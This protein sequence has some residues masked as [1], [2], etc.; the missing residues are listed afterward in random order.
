[1][2]VL[3]ILEKVDEI[4]RIIEELKRESKDLDL[5][6]VCDILEEYQIMLLD[7]TVG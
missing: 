7:K 6:L 3:E 2:T 4:D 5:N 1:M